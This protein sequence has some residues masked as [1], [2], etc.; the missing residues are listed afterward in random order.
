MRIHHLALR[1]SDLGRAEGFYGRFLGLAVERRHRD[2]AGVLRA[3][4][5]RAGPTILMLE[6][7][8]ALEDGTGGS[9]HL[10][11]L[12]VDDPDDLEVWRR[13]CE[14]RGVPIE[15]HTEFTLYVRDPD[16]HRVG[17][18]VFAGPRSS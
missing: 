6:R 7:A 2:D 15:G 12:H 11:G 4:W 14:A 1:V 18:T 13:R 9:G 16:G 5:L 10:L 3:V 8:L 17:L